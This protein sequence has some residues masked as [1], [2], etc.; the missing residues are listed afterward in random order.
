M[1][2]QILQDQRDRLISEREA[3]WAV[4]GAPLI[5]IAEKRAFSPE[6]KV[7]AKDAED[8][9]E[10]FTRRIA[11]TD[12]AIETDRAF[13]NSGFGGMLSTRP[14]AAD[15]AEA[16]WIDANTGQA[17]S[18]RSS[19]RFADLPMS[20]RAVTGPDAA[21]M[22]AHEDI[23]AMVR[24]LATGSGG[25]TAIVPTSWSANII[26]LARAKAA[27]IEAG[28][29]VIPMETKTVQVGRVT[30]DPTAAFRTEGSTITPSDPSFDTVTL[31]AKT[32][33]VLT[34]ASMEWAQDVDNGAALIT[35]CIAK[36]IANKIDQVALYG[37]ITTGAGAINLPTPPNPRGVLA[38]LLANK[39]ANVLGDAVNGTTQTPA[40]YWGEI[41]DL[42]YTVRD[43]NEEPG[44]LIW[45]TKVGRQYAKAVDTTGQPLNLPADVEALKRLSSNQ[46]PSY[47]KGTMTG[48]ATDVFAGDWSQL[49]IGQ[50]L[51]LTITVLT[52]RYAENG[53]IGIVAHW[54]GDI[55]PARPGAFAVYRALQGAA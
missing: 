28:A 20:Q 40:T 36:A 26:D 53:Q 32:Q 14:G 46:I 2:S 25:G 9:F 55:Q 44:A 35:D 47:T 27:V 24:A 52:E 18:L 30:G 17:V 34:I 10:D 37:G 12:K 15:A 43:S 38:A 16:R 21:A 8:A 3:H 19:D 7:R 13:T 23:G 33:S 48:R 42:L 31:E 22:A 54:R 50:R 4:H 45:N 1:T 29:A 39:P 5:D 41:I 6:E 11:L 49:L 51:G